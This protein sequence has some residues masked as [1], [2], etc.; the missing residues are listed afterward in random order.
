MGDLET[1]WQLFYQPGAC[2]EV[3]ALGLSGGNK[4]WKGWAGGVVAGYFDDMESFVNCVSS[5]DEYGKAE[6]IYITLNP[7]NPDCLLVPII[8]WS[9]SVRTMQPQKMMT[10]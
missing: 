4:R 8:V 1:T 7:L 9:V 6:A 5:L 10:S 3:R 2:V